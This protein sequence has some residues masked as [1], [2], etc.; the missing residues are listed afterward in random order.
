MKHPLLL[1]VLGAVIS[2]VFS[3]EPPACDYEHDIRTYFCKRIRDVFPNI[4]YGNYHLQCEQCNIRIFTN[5]TFPFSNSLVSFNVSESAIR[6]ITS[7]AFSSLSNIQYLYL[8][9]NIIE[10]IEPGAFAGLRQV[11]EVHLENNNL[12]KIVPGFLDDLE[13]NT[14]DLKNNKIK[15]LPSGVFGGSLGVLILDLSKNR[16]KTIEPDAFAGLESLEVLNLENNELCHLTCGV[17]K[18]LS[19]LRQ[20]NLADNK[21]SKFTVGTFS[22][23][24]HLTSLNLANNSISAFDGNILIPFNHLSKLDLSRN[25]I[26][27]FDANSVHVNVPTLRVLRIDDNLLSCIHLINVIQYF[28]KVHVEVVN[29]VGRYHV[30]N[31]IGIACTEIILNH[32]VD[33][34]QFLKVA[35]EDTKKSISYC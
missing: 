25:G 14:V 17:F 2:T 31:V 28:K 35:E 5:K 10:D 26:Y 22:G 3:A 20:L 33:F 24:T 6:V 21:L 34:E 11:Y 16:I 13:A 18:H 27:Y 9:N 4:F 15:H 12:G 30:Q 7:R 8:Q 23:L 29:T 1:C 32:S 19:T